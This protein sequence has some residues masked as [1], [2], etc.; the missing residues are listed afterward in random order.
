V[1][2]A[3]FQFAESADFLR[4]ADDARDWNASPSA[5]G[6]RRGQSDRFALKFRKPE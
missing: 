2:A 6:E 3:G 1:Q 5:A 4:N